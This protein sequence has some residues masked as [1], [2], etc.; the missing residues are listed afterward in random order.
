MLRVVPLSA[1]GRQARKGPAG[2]ALQVGGPAQHDVGERQGQG[3]VDGKPLDCERESVDAPF[4]LQ[5]RSWL[6]MCIFK[7]VDSRHN[8]SGV[9]AWS[10]GQLICT[11]FGAELAANDAFNVQEIWDVETGNELEDNFDQ[12]TATQIAKAR[13]S[14]SETAAEI[15]SWVRERDPQLESEL[16]SPPSRRR[17]NR[18]GRHGSAGAQA[19]PLERFASEQPSDHIMC[20]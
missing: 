4:P 1:S 13:R 19:P 14:P 15:S 10:E 9:R 6:V 20:K 7:D 5:P 3:D 2:Q 12:P 17:H 16:P 18:E 8:V 11:A